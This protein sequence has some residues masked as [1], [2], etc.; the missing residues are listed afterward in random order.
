MT[1]II[2]IKCEGGIVM[3]ADGAATMGSLGQQ[4]I[5]QSVTKLDSVANKAVL[6]VSGPVSIGQKFKS[7]LDEHFDGFTFADKRQYIATR[8][9]QQLFW[10]PIE[11]EMNI[12][13][14]AQQCIGPIANQSAISS[15]L[16]ALQVENELRLY[17][18]TQQCS[19]EEVTSELT[20]AAIGSGLGNAHMFLAFLKRVF[21][22]NALPSIAD[23][24]FYTV[25]AL[26]HA[27][28]TAPGGIADPKQIM[29][30]R[31]DGDGPE[32]VIGELTQPEIIEHLQNY[33]SAEAYLR[34]Y[35]DQ[36]SGDPEDSS[37]TAFPEP[38]ADT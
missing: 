36:I 21:F 15:A 38:P 8:Q 19:F 1:L 28:R 35:R 23:G 12:A 37:Q 29:T 3:G 20:F 24:V 6:G 5:R 31:L 14:K 18:C 17:E 32:L 16:L 33:V 9:L 13:V 22:E 10:A 11:Q 30:I 25:W 4:T 34:G 27:I 26:D 7:I 2:G